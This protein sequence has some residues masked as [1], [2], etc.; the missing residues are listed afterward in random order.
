MNGSDRVQKV[1]PFALVG[2]ISG[3]DGRVDE[4]SGM[5]DRQQVAGRA[6]GKAVLAR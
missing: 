2:R 4:R 1:K 5:M 6:G 3:F